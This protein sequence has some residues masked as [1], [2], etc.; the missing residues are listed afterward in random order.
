MSSSLF[1]FSFVIENAKPNCLD[2][3]NSNIYSCIL[4]C[5]SYTEHSHLLWIRCDIFYINI[6]CRYYI[7]IYMCVCVCVCVCVCT[8]VHIY[9]IIYIYIYN[10]YNIY[11]YTQYISSLFL[12][13]FIVLLLIMRSQPVYFLTYMTCFKSHKASYVR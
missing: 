12:F 5:W 11:I 3:V 9:I 6:V 7:Y 13:Y 8:Y 2:C 10:I 4:S 1:Y